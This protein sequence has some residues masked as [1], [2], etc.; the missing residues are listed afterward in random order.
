MDS[1]QP[2]SPFILVVTQWAHD[3]SDRGV[4][5]GGDVWVPAHGLLLRKVCLVPGTAE[6]NTESPIRYQSLGDQSAT[7]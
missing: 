6:T 7:W 5:D 4:R 1:Y 3:Q 2:C